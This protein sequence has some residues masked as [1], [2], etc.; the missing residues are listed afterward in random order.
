MFQRW[1]DG[2]PNGAGDSRIIFLEIEVEMTSGRFHGRYFAYQI[3]ASVS[4]LRIF[5][6]ML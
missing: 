1:K 4:R 6:E 3:K 2:S 5:F